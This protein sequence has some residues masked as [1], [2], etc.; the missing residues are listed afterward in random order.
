MRARQSPKSWKQRTSPIFV[1][2][3]FHSAYYVARRLYF[4]V[5]EPRP[6][7]LPD[8][9]PEHVP[10]G[11]LVGAQS[12]RDDGSVDV[13]LHEGLSKSESQF[14]GVRFVWACAVQLLYG[15]MDQRD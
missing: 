9:V 10:G 8:P 7:R 2:I 6:Q 3:K 14:P 13:R 1:R 12:H 11:A 4:S 15:G 5:G